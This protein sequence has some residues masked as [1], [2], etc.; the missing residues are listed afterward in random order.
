MGDQKF[1]YSFSANRNMA[2]QYP[3]IVEFYK[4][5]AYT[6]FEMILTESEWAAFV[7]TMGSEGYTFHEV[8][9]VPYFAPEI[10]ITEP[11]ADP[12]GGHVGFGIETPD[13]HTAHILGDPGMSQETRA[14]LAGL[15]DAAFKMTPAEWEELARNSEGKDDAEQ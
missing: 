4:M 1:E 2:G 3:P 14:A 15:V 5:V 12:L 8:E 9:R 11:A 7:A 6:R 10:V 13:G